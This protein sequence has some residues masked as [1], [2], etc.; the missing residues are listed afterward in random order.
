MPTRTGADYPPGLKEEFATVREA[1]GD[2][3]SVG[4][5]PVVNVVQ[6]W[7]IWSMRGSSRPRMVD[8]YQVLAMGRSRRS[9]CPGRPG[10][11]RLAPR[12]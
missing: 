6:A 5:Y 11:T 10:S 7:D 8:S 2:Q 3:V 9:Q 12:R 1:E 4:R